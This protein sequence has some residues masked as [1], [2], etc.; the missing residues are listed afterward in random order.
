MNINNAH[1]SLLSRAFQNDP[2]F[3]HLFTNQKYQAQ[4]E[5]L[6]RFII[7]ENRLSDGLILTDD[8]TEPSYVAILDPPKNLKKVSL[9]AKLRLNI[10]Q[11]LLLLHLP[12]SVLRFLSKYQ[13]QITE[14]A[15]KEPHYYLTMLGVDPASQ[16]KG[17]GKKALQAI[18]KIADSSETPYPVALDTE[19][20]D[21]VTYY[22]KFG[23]QLID[24]K[25]INGLTVYCMTR[26]AKDSGPRGRTLP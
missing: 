9:G 7:K 18:H 4:S 23:Y 15:P 19:N 26:P 24:T 6:I 20:Q 14:S 16:G 1:V 5:A 12:F 3:V 13:E 11:L 2:L 25:V 22:Q 8:P 17:V 21:N 10:E